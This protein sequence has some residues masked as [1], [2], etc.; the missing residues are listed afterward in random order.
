M[1]TDVYHGL[2]LIEKYFH[3]NLFKGEVTACSFNQ[4]LKAGLLTQT[5][6]NKF[7]GQASQQIW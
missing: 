1:S 2:L 4:S 6:I 7:K 3:F 5:C